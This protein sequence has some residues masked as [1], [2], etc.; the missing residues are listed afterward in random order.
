MDYGAL[1]PEINSVR[2][3]TGPGSGPMLAAATVWDML[4]EQL[5]ATAVSYESAVSGLDTVW[6]G[7]SSA[8]MTAAAAPYRAWLSTTAGQAEDTAM[9]ARAALGAYET[10]FAATVP[11]PAIAANRAQL[12]ALVA[13]NFFGQ[14]TPAI[15]ATEATYAEMWAQDTAAMYGYADSAASAAHIKSFSQPPQTT[16]STATANH[17]AAIGQTGAATTGMH[18]QTVPQLMS[19]TPQSLHS[20]TSPA[21]STVTTQAGSDPSLLAALNQYAIGELSPMALIEFGINPQLLGVQN[22][23]L[24]QAAVGL[25]EGIQKAFAPGSAGLLQLEMGST[26]PTVSPAGGPMFASA[27]G[28]GVSANI[29]RAGLAGGLSVPQAW[30]SPAPAIRTTAMTLPPNT[31]ATAAPAALATEGPGNLLNNAAMSSLAGRAM[32]NSSDRAA[33]RPTGTDNTATAE[34]ETVSNIFVIPETD[35]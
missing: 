30:T 22:Y 32:N 13:T 20:L 14:N 34:A 12:M 5:H 4:A 15:M 3:Y 6:Q 31:P 21:T 7:P 28:G 16:N 10:A 11:P 18:A 33:A 29:G 9:Q 1:P 17:V 27:S 26:A 25:T 23:L 8:H 35:E 24:P 19:A 2:M